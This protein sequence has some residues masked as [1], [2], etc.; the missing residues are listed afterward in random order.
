MTSLMNELGLQGE[1]I[2]L[3]HTLV[4]ATS[5]ALEAQLKGTSRQ[6]TNAIEIV[7]YGVAAYC[8]LSGESVSYVTL[9]SYLLGT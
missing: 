5:K 8:V 2:T 6:V 9:V 4:L 1:K 3:E 7:G